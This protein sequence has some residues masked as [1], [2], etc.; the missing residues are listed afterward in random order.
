M[1]KLEKIE[2]VNTVIVYGG[3]Y[4]KALRDALKE[5]QTKNGR[6]LEAKKRRQEDLSN[7]DA[8]IEDET[9]ETSVEKKQAIQVY[10]RTIWTGFYLFGHCG[11][12]PT[13]RS[14]LRSLI[15]QTNEDFNEV[16]L[17]M[18]DLTATANRVN[19]MQIQMQHVAPPSI[20]ETLYAQIKILQEQVCSLMECTQQ[21]AELIKELRIELAHISQNSL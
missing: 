21:Q 13:G 18:G 15:R 17:L 20:D 2:K 14:M 12:L 10:L 8:L 1:P 6:K 9:H 19:E 4:L 11:H 3:V 7:I 16:R 5:Y